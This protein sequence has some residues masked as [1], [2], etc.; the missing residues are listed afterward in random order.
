M[1]HLDPR[2]FGAGQLQMLSHR[3]GGMKQEP[4]QG[5]PYHSEEMFTVVL[6]AVTAGRW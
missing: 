3:S 5:T 4:V 1:I 6:N 2:A